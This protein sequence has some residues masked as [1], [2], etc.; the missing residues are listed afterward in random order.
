M[1]NT[2]KPLVSIIIP[3][4]NTENFVGRAIDSVL[5]QTYENIEIILVNDGSTDTSVEVC[6][7]YAQKH[8]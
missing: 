1:F 2:G 8:N 5:A 6:E 7:R 4:Y 3:V